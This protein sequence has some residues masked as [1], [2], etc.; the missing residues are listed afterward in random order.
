MKSVSD[1]KALWVSFVIS[2]PPAP[3]EL[4]IACLA[5]SQCNIYK[6]RAGC[7]AAMTWVSLNPSRNS[8]SLLVFQPGEPLRTGLGCLTFVHKRKLLSNW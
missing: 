1:R 6:K 4:Q 2:N 7:S 8:T 5:A 3:G